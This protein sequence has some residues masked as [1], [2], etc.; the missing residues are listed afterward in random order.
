M[1][2]HTIAA[3][4]S[5]ALVA[6]IAG[7]A[8]AAPADAATP[9]GT[10]AAGT[11]APTVTHLFPTMSDG[12]KIDAYVVSPS[13]PG[14]HPVLIAPAS[15]L[16]DGREYLG[17]ARGLARDGGYLVISYAARGFAESGGK[18]GVADRRDVADAR[19]LIDWA[20]ADLHGD[21]KRVGMFGISYG[22][23]ISLLTAAADPRVG[24]VVAMSGWTDLARALVPNDTPNRLAIAGLLGS[25]AATTRLGLEPLAAGA[26]WFLGGKTTGVRTLAAS[27]S[28]IGVIDG[29]NRRKVPVLLANEWQD[30]AFVPSDLVDYFNRLTGPKRLQFVPGLHATA[31]MP[32]ALSGLPDP[33]W[34]SAGRWLDRYVRGVANGIDREPGVQLVDVSRPALVGSPP[35]TAYRGFSSWAGVTRSTQRRYLAASGSATSKSRT[36]TLGTKASTGWSWTVTGAVATP[37]D[38]HRPAA[39]SSVQRSAGLVAQTAPFPAG[40]TLGGRPRLHLTMA[41]TGK[42]ATAF[43]TLYEVPVVGPGKPISFQPITITA[44]AGRATTFD[45]TLQPLYTRLAPGSRL[46]LVVDTADAAYAGASKK[47]DKVTFSSKAGS[48]AYLDVPVSN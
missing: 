13:G 2:R 12:V 14:P 26:Q 3:T 37:A 28:P 32:G 41:S 9:A 7:P 46:A 21:P 11:T 43:A 40:I 5:L 36:A 18:I 17:A 33:T 42:A 38:A 8:I 22:A 31:E 35:A 6:T 45:L 30:V 34:R 47:G 29:I 15:W 16:L 24:A 44:P 27:R 4:L 23:G 1:R 39:L 48:P 19:E 10:V 20:V 25:G